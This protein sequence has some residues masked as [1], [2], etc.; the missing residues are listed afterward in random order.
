VLHDHLR[1]A[2]S[3]LDGVVLPGTSGLKPLD[4]L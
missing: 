1:V 3:A 2:R 4:L